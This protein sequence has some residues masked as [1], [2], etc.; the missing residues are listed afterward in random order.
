LKLV[1]SDLFQDVGVTGLIYRERLATIRT[2]YL[3]HDFILSLNGGTANA[4]IV[5]FPAR[6]CSMTV[7]HIYDTAFPNLI[8]T[9]K[10]KF[11][12]CQRLFCEDV[13]LPRALFLFTEEFCFVAVLG[14][15]RCTINDE[16][17]E[18]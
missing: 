14:F 3:L 10:Q 7:P 6:M 11:I 17:K 8:G 1:I 16:R 12:F 13:R 9:K 4:R 2:N 15:G 18:S 5:L